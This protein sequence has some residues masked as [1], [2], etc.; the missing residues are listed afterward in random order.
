[1]RTWQGAWLEHDVDGLVAL[2]AEEGWIVDPRMPP[3]RGHAEIRAYFEDLLRK[4]TDYSGVME[5]P[6]MFGDD[7]FGARCLV[8]LK[9]RTTGR[10]GSIPLSLYFKL[11]E[12]GRV[13]QCE[14]FYD[15]VGMAR[16]L[17]MTSER[18]CSGVA[19]SAISA[20]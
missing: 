4:T 13:R 5:G 11:D 19:E 16:S 10:E 1:M 7:A 17:G 6:Y 3:L 15:T 9:S 18:A 2:F 14:E 12:R 8:R 20:S